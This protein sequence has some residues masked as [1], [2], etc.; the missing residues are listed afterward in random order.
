MAIAAYNGGPR[1]ISEYL[2]GDNS[3]LPMDEFIEEIGAHETRNYVRKVTDH[4]VRY[5]TIYGS[6]EE[7]TELLQALLP[8]AQLPEPEGKVRF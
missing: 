4:L 3:S 8:P 1:R 7:R 2:Q 5:L 6:E